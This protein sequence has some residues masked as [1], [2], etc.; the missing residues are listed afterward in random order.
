MKNTADRTKFFLD[1]NPPSRK[2]IIFIAA[3]LMFACTSGAAAQ[4]KIKCWTNHEGIRE[5]GNV[6]PPEFAQGRFEEKS[7]GGVTLD[8]TDAARSIDDVKAERLHKQQEAEAAEQAAA[9]AAKD[10]VLLDTFSSEDDM[11]LAR[12]GQIV[13]IN[14]QV[15][16]TESH[17][18]KL[19]KSLDVLIEEAADHER[20]GNAPPEKLVA[21]I[22]S[23][24]DQIEADEK[25]IEAKHAERDAIE[26]K[27]DQDIARL[28]TLKGLTP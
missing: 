25:F 7:A 15:K 28:R 1:P 18:E 11:I 24:R 14:S 5:C 27:F 2:K 19:S 6:V 23:L 9:Q 20:R 17:I 3:S 21:D 16:I 8:T 10:R 12:D 13:H 22:Q 4:T 26:E